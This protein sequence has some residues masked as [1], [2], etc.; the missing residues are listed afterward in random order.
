MGDVHP[1]DGGVLPGY[2][3]LMDSN[4]V[5]FKL[6]S[7]DAREAFVFPNIILS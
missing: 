7:F 3:V 5:T 2:S 4:I 6:K 1:I